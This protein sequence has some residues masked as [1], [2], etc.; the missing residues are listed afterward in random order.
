[1]NYY[2]LPDISF[3]Q[4][5]PTTPQGVDFG[6]MAKRTKGVIIRAGQNTWTDKNFTDHWKRAKEAGLKRGAYWFYDSRVSPKRQAELFAAL[7]RNDPPEMEAWAD[8]EDNYGGAFTG[9]GYWYDFMENFRMLAPNIPMGVYTGYYYWTE[10]TQTYPLKKPTANQLA[11]F[12]QYPLW[13]AWYNKTTPLIPKPWKEWL[14]W[15]FTDNGDGKLYGVES[16]NIDL[17]YFNGNEKDFEYL[18]GVIKFP[19]DPPKE[20][21]TL[22]AKYG[23]NLVEYRRK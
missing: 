9:W 11:Y 2:T 3:W 22:V 12:A 6:I 17:N 23:K 19:N 5:D 15:Q 4:D 16:K 7:L 14:Y 10:R 1:M 18:Y 13:I 20:S 8:F 21:T